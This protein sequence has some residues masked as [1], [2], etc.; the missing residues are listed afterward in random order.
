MYL[1]WLR[2][3][4]LCTCVVV[5]L[6]LKKTA[7]LMEAEG[8]SLCVL[9][10]V[11][12]QSA[13]FP[14]SIVYQKAEGKKHASN[15]SVLTAQPST[16]CEC[17]GCCWGHWGHRGLGSPLLL[18]VRG[19]PAAPHPLLPLPQ[20]PALRQPQLFSPVTNTLSATGSCQPR[21]IPQALGMAQAT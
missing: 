20:L 19:W 4:I 3:V 9:K 1:G 2:L 13:N 14:F 16:E 21:G 15:P 10:R 17:C 5:F 8:N 6:T 12:E 7:R 11:P 18:P